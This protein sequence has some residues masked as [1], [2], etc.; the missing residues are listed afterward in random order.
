MV[1][2]KHKH[3]PKPVKRVW[4]VTADAPQGEYV[5]PDAPAPEK[6]TEPALRPDSGWHLSSFELSSGLEV[7]DTPDTVPADLIDKLFKP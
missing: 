6:T 1:T 2:R 4:R 3:T 5:D 7:N